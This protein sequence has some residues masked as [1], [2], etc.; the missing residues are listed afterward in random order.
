VLNGRRAVVIHSGNSRLSH[1]RGPSSREIRQRPDPGPSPPQ[2]FC[3]IPLYVTRGSGR[4]RH[5]MGVTVLE[6]SRLFVG[7][8]NGRATTLQRTLQYLM[9]Y[10]GDRGRR[11][12]PRIAND[13][14]LQRDQPDAA[15]SSMRWRTFRSISSGGCCTTSSLVNRVFN[16]LFTKSPNRN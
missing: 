3:L 10:N 13:L 8:L 2:E 15:C 11:K 1:K 9:N 5:G 6:S 4:A 12:K 7:D 14:S 16:V